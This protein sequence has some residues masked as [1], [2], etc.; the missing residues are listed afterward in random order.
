MP[1]APGAGWVR[2]RSRTGR[3]RSG[4]ARVWP[5]V[6]RGRR[7]QRPAPPMIPHRVASPRDA[8]R[9]SRG[10]SRSPLRC[11]AARRCM[12]SRPS[13]RRATPAAPRSSSR[14]RRR[15]RRRAGR[16][17]ASRAGR[18][19]GP[20]RGRPARGLCVARQVGRCLVEPVGDR[21]QVAVEV[22][23]P[24][25]PRV[26]D[27]PGRTSSRSCARTS[28]ST[29]R[30]AGLLERSSSARRLVRARCLARIGS[31]RPTTCTTLA[32]VWVRTADRAHSKS[33]RLRTC[34]R[35]DQSP[36]RRGWRRWRQP[37]SRRAVPGRCRAGCGRARASGCS[38]GGR[39]S[40]STAADAEQ[41]QSPHAERCSASA[42]ARSGARAGRRPTRVDEGREALDPLSALEGL[43][44]TLVGERREA[45][46][47][48]AGPGPLT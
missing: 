28:A 16:A 13:A 32:L 48:D 12:P 17:A 19:S 37:G 14:C 34:G 22:R 26:G 11:A 36:R 29:G 4:P 18:R 35:R 1:A 8:R 42:S 3:A 9:V 41:E 15:R 5:F 46:A 39:G 24:A 43:G 6:V 7:V 40:A 47:L 45:G 27:E 20:R 33:S 21:P 25:Q 38:S 10:P 30:M 23:E 2:C 44:H 31:T